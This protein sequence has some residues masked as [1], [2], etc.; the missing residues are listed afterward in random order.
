MVGTRNSGRRKPIETLKKHG[1]YRRDRHDRN[2]PGPSGKMP[3]CPDWLSDDAHAEWDRVLPELEELGTV[4]ATDYAVLVGYCES[5]SQYK[6]ASEM[7]AETGP[8]HE[9]RGDGES[10]RHPLVFVLKD[11][12]EA[13]LKFARELG[14]SP[15]S[16]SAVSAVS[17][18]V[19]ED[20]LAALLRRRGSLN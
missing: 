14:L 17:G 18:G 6:M 10:R 9:P 5:F 4:G 16:R 20:P 11:S 7:L 15:S 13:M 1:T 3:A 2:Q 8:L 19:D 12:R